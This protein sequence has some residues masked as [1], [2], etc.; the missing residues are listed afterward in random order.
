[1]K[2]FIITIFS[3]LLQLNVVVSTIG[4][5][6][7]G[8]LIGG[9][10]GSLFGGPSFNTT[11]AFVGAIIAFSNAAIVSGAGLALDRIRELLEDQNSRLHEQ[12]HRQSLQ[13]EFES[14][15]PNSVKQCPQCAEYVK[16]AAKVCRFCG[17]TFEED[18]SILPSKVLE[19]TADKPLTTLDKLSLL[20]RQLDAGEITGEEFARQHQEI[21]SAP[22]T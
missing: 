15:N 1:M 2:D 5:F 7:L 12:V 6:I 20:R 16:K 13:S 8:G 11:T 22:R 21:L 14:S 17:H 3:P 19:Q 18:K 9:L 10:G 4:G